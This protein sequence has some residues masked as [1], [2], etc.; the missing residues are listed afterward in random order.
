MK[1]LLTALFFAITFT[2]WAQDNV[3]KKEKLMRKT[4]EQKQKEE[5]QKAP[6]AWYKKYT[7][8]KD[9]VA[10]DTSLTIKSLYKF[11]YLKRDTFGLLAFSNDG[12]PYN[13]LNF[14]LTQFKTLPSFGHNAKQYAYYNP[15]DILYYNVPTPV[16][17]LFY[18]SVVEQG[19]NVDA[20][21][22]V[23]TSKQFNISVNYR[24]IR[25]LG[26]YLNQLSSNGNF[27]LTSSYFTKNKRYAI[28]FHFT[29][30]DISNN[31]N[32]G[33]TTPSDY[34]GSN[35]EF[36]NRARLAVFLTDAK[37]FLKGKRVF[38]EHQFR[39]N[40]KDAQNNVLLSHIFN[41]EHKF[42]EYSQSSLSA[43]SQTSGINN[44]RFG[45]A[46]ADSGFKDQSRN[47]NLYNKASLS[48]ENK[49]I[50][51][52]GFFIENNIN[53][54]Y[55]NNLSDYS[56]N[57]MPISSQL[58]NN[59]TSIGGQYQYIKNKWKGTFMVSNAISQKTVRNLTANLQYKLNEKNNF[60][61]TYENLSKL[62]DNIYSL[63][64]SNYTTYNWE[65]NFLNQKINTLSA[66]ANTQW[67]NAEVKI[68]TLDDYL[69]FSNLS[70]DFNYQLVTP[71]QFS[72][73]IKYLSVKAEKE[74]KYRKWAL[75]N[76]VLFQQ[77]V[78]NEAI[79]N[80]PK[81][82]TRN[83]L[84]YSNYVFKRAMYLQT[85]ITLNY[86]TSYYAN[87]YN[88]VLSEFFVQNSKKIGNY[89]VLDIFANARIRQTRIFFIA[90]HLN[91]LFSQNKNY[92]TPNM[93]YRDFV[94]RVGLVWNFFQ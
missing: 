88:P 40:P 17:E 90:E 82:T 10:V 16:T 69:Y 54:Y 45:T 31:E 46:L 33:I 25:S 58:K 12:Q 27:T 19:Q 61:F 38:F 44:Y 85:G 67:A 37:S 9:T 66:R 60:S 72:G 77:T 8:E 6:I 48:Y 23:N 81:F 29:G 56:V 84:Y 70:T 1:N 65:N 32:G 11:N 87:D 14:G 71:K 53:T 49:T 76:T 93:P 39:I 51:T 35:S 59:I 41:Y 83:S 94:L 50:G 34:E 13:Q 64:Q 86:F 78:Q 43:L 4:L 21:I 47:N 36:T 24:G 22:S 5:S 20:F 80:V 79:V 52:V 74:I 15:E 2:F 75:D 68:T 73:T 7:L 3:P 63:S 57:T 42:Y 26:K 92:V 91:S 55:Y 62:P 18:K 30:Q 89:P 28:N